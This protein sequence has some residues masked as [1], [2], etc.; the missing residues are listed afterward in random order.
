MVVHACNPSYSGGRGKIWIWGQPGQKCETL[1]WRHGQVV[2][3]L[4]SRHKAPSSDLN[5][6]KKKKSKRSGGVAQVVEPSKHKA[7]SSIPDTV[8]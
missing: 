5:A 7:L 8:K 4:P 1:G 2:E 6:A 3:S